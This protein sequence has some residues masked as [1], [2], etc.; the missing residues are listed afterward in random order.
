MI[1]KGML[2]KNLNIRPEESYLNIEKSSGSLCKLCCLAWVMAGVL[3]FLI[4]FFGFF[5]ALV[6][7]FTAK[8]T[9]LLSFG[10]VGVKS[11]G[12]CS[13]QGLLFLTVLAFLLICPNFVKADESTFNLH[14]QGSMQMLPGTH[15]V[16]QGN[17][18]SE[19]SIK[20]DGVVHI[21]NYPQAILKTSDPHFSSL[22]ITNSCV[23]LRSA[24]HISRELYMTEG[25][26]IVLNQY[27]ITL[28][29][30]TQLL[31][32]TDCSIQ[33][34]GTGNV[35]LEEQI[36]PLNSYVVHEVSN[37]FQVVDQGTGLEISMQSR[38]VAYQ[39]I[40]NSVY[41]SVPRTPPAPPP[42]YS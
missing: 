36:H 20:G 42:K 4:H 1:T 35:L 39:P 38:L 3:P 17:L 18:M 28:L 22:T 37:I 30:S 16:V 29:P 15:L 19:A 11:I 41:I 33:R 9:R 12:T 31:L 6:C 24:L 13:P 21:C 2:R 40:T 32:E 8:N 27:D 7:I 23:Y 5:R 14:L 26:Q 10:H 25:A 34:N